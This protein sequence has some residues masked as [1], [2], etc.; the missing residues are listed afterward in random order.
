[1]FFTVIKLK[2]CKCKNLEN[3]SLNN[4]IGRTKCIAWSWKAYARGNSVSSPWH[5]VYSHEFVWG[6]ASRFSL[7][8]DDGTTKYQ[9]TLCWEMGKKER[10]SRFSLKRFVVTKSPFL[11]SPSHPLPGAQALYPRDSLS[12]MFDCPLEPWKGVGGNTLWSAADTS[13]VIRSVYPSSRKAAECFS[14]WASGSH[15][16]E[17][18]SWGPSVNWNNRN[19]RA[20]E[21]DKGVT[22]VNVKKHVILNYRLFLKNIACASFK[23]TSRRK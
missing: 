2:T 11:L 12:R 7:R 19:L 3:I 20:R 6:R 17:E 13:D 8:A 16:M 10:N 15:H 14:L 5:L 1:M 4:D 9:F 22:G 18:H 21:E 23:G